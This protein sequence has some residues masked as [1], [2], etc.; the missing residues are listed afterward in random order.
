MYSERNEAYAVRFKVGPLCRAS[1][2]NGRI[3]T[4]F[5]EWRLPDEEHTGMAE[6]AV[7]HRFTE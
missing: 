6:V 1:L 7:S 5:E 4:F 3:Q 2:P